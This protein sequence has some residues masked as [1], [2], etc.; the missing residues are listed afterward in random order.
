MSLRRDLDR[1]TARVEQMDQGGTRGVGVLS[2]QVTDLAKDLVELK[3]ETRGY[4]AAHQL[5]H[6]KERS[7]R[8][9]GHRWLITTSL[10]SLAALATAV[11]VLL[12]VAAHLH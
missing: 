1:L 10:A 9:A 5:E 6:E 3:T 7:A 12:D 4:E 8:V 11:G 2:A